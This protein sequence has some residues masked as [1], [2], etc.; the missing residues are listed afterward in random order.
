MKSRKEYPVFQLLENKSKFFCPAKWTELYLYLNHGNSNSC[1]HPIPH[2]IPKELLDDPSVLHNTPHKLNMQ[3]LMMDG[4]RPNE[5]HM[6]WHIEDM[7]PDVVTDRI[8]KSEL[9]ADKIS[10]LTVD[11]TYVPEFIEVVFDN[12]CNLNCSYCDSGQSSSWAAKIHT[13]PL[14]LETDYRQLYSTIHV[15]PGTTKP[16][17][18]NAWVKWWSQI[19]QQVRYLK[20]SG[21]EPLMSKNFWNF[22]QTLGQEKLRSLLINTNL[23]VDPSLVKRL[24]QVSKLFDSVELGVS[25]DAVGDIAEYTRQG[26]DYQRLV[27]N[28]DIWCTN[29]NGKIYLQSTVN[30]LS[31]WGLL[32]K[33][34]LNIELKNKYPNTI[35]PLYSTLVRFP[36]FQSVLLLPADLRQQLSKQID[37]WLGKNQHWLTDHEADYLYKTQKYLVES[38]NH[39]QKFNKDQLTVDFKKFL[40][41]YD[42][43]SKKSYKEIYPIEFVEWVD[44]I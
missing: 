33:F 17:Y 37:I 5:C 2:K 21:G 1:H 19:K 42:K 40:L 16:E 25:I 13:S 44:S 24:I 6:C 18:Y 41:Y 38:V 36:E 4:H 10:A 27:D 20:I 31:I 14:V 39:L 22:T 8:I 34:E 32:D 43:S 35:M 3:Q 30:I 7:D 11:P 26:L 9:W 29:T 28:I 12:Y 23:S 15:E